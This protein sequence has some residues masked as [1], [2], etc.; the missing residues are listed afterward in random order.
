MIWSL[1]REQ[2]RA[3]RRYII[4]A[5]VV[6]V[7]AVTTA[8]YAGLLGATLRS[9]ATSQAH[10]LVADTDTIAFGVAT[11]SA[12][13]VGPDAVSSQ[14]VREAVATAQAQGTRVGAMASLWNLTVGDSHSS[15]WY[16]GAA[17]ALGDVD[18]NALVVKGTAP[19]S[20]QVAL[21]GA[22]AQLLGVGIGD[23]L[24]VRGYGEDTGLRVTVS[25][26]TKS[27]FSSSGLALMGLPDVW[28][29]WDDLAAYEAA[30]ANTAP[31]QY[32]E[33]P[34]LQL[35]WE[36]DSQVL[37]TLLGGSAPGFPGSDAGQNQTL[38]WTLLAASALTIGAVA[39]AFAF[40]RA[41]A[42]TRTQWVATARALGASRRHMFLATLAE[43]GALVVAGL[44]VGFPLG[45]LAATLHLAAVHHEVPDAAIALAPALSLV[46]V[47]AALGLAVVLSLVIAGVPAF[48]AARVSPAAALKPENDITAAEVGRR[49]RFWPVALI[50]AGTGVAAVLTADPTQVNGGPIY[51]LV[52]ELIFVVLGIIVAN[53]A[54][55]WLVPALG[56]R[57]SRRPGRSAMVAGDSIAARPR[58]YS[59]PAFLLALGVGALLFA[60]VTG[61]VQAASDY[62]EQLRE[63]AGGGFAT[64]DAP[65]W[66]W[67]A[68]VIVIGALTAL[69]TVIAVATAAA[70]A[71]ERAVRE[72]LGVTVR[73]TR[74]G[75]GLAHV[76][77]L[78]VGTLVGVGFA[79]ASVAVWWAFTPLPGM[80]IWDAQYA[81]YSTTVSAVG[82]VA[83]FALVLAV[84]TSVLVA[85][86]APSTAPL[87]R[88]E[89]SA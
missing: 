73:Q 24:T 4:A 54:T 25:G 88:V 46:A 41:Q 57:L 48:W 47:A 18:M 51:S 16:P 77:A 5:A 12:D 8:V 21:S 65:E 66:L 84:A 56:R 6:V 71:R 87:S 14:R 45:Y 9:A 82:I 20:G 31:D 32:R 69:A 44:V 72:A 79:A 74:V 1:T 59:V 7:L 40:G 38:A 29:A 27:S 26:L 42:R 89:V 10:A 75:V 19:E 86:L 37:S 36:G 2:L 28:V 17:A 33:S 70:T 3:Q 55:R 83:G 63:R 76:T 58:Q 62:G 67:P 78:A 50:W 60:S 52:L 43:A 30:L 34:S 81:A 64:Y 15:Q 35:T 11:E 39:M 68:T 61:I 13:R 23:E 49:V 53:E 80:D 22:H 85:R